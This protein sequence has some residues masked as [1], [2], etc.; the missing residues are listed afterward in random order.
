M[1]TLALILLALAFPASAHA[2]TDQQMLQRFTP[3]AQQAFPN[4]CAPTVTFHTK[5]EMIAQEK[6][7]LG[8]TWRAECRVWMVT[9]LDPQ[10]FC[11]VLTHEYGHLAGLEHVAQSGQLMSG[12]GA[13]NYE[14]CNVAAR[15]T[16]PELKLE[17]KRSLAD[18]LDGSTAFPCR[19]WRALSTYRYRTICRVHSERYEIIVN[20][21]TQEFSWA[22]T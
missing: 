9:G 15:L 18:T 14:P 10:L 13:V 4:V 16:L 12:D 11:T 20:V 22:Y 2:A 5:A 19:P 8:L 7:A 1:R 17:A 21:R 6:G 3:I